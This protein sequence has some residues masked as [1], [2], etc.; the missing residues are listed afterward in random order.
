MIGRGA[1]QRQG[2]GRRTR[3]ARPKAGAVGGKLTELGGDRPRSYDVTDE[4]LEAVAA[5]APPA[6]EEATA[7]A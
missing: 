5:A 4:A 2:G 7:G 1:R 6:A 3:G